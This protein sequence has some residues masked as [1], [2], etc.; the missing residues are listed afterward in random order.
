MIGLRK[1]KIAD[2]CFVAFI[3]L[4]ALIVIIALIA[5]L[6][7]FALA[8]LL[9]HILFLIEMIIGIICIFLFW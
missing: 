8:G 3:A 5:P 1:K 9:I 2:Y 4:F 6:I 7:T